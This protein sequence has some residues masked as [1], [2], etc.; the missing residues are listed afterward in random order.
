MNAKKSCGSCGNPLHSND[1]GGI[2]PRCLI[3][4]ALQGDA[5]NPTMD[6]AG[7]NYP[8]AE[9]LVGRF[10]NLEIMHL[11]GHGGMGAVYLARQT[12]LDRM[13]AL[14]V[15]SPKLG[16]DPQFTERFT[17][18]AKTLAKLSH[19]N[20]V[21]VFDYGLS[22]NIN[23]LVMEYV[24]GIN[25]RDAIEGGR[26]TAEES[27]GI[28]PQICDALQYAHNQGVIHRDI[29]PEN[30][31]LD[32]QGRV[33]IA[34]FGLAK[35]L[36]SD[37]NAFKLTGT[38]QV[39][40]TR[41]Y[42][43]PEQIEHSDVVDHRADIYSL[44]VVF[45]ELLTGELPIG[46]FAVPSEKAKVSHGLDEVVMRTLEKEPAR[47]F[48]QASEI[49]T[50]VESIVE[51]QPFSKPSPEPVPPVK[52]LGAFPFSVGLYQ[53]L[54]CARG[55]AHLYAD[56]IELEYEVVDEVLGEIKSAP[57]HTTV[58][59]DSLLHVRFVKGYLSDNVEF[60]TDRIDA[61]KD[62]PGS[63]Q[64]KFSLGTK[65]GD[66]EL[67]TRFVDQCDRLRH[68]P[69]SPSP[70]YKQST[71]H[72]EYRQPVPPRKT[73]VFVL[74]ERLGFGD[75][76][77]VSREDV[78]EKLKV[79][80]ITFLV[81]GIIHMLL[82]IRGFL[83]ETIWE[84]IE[85]WTSDIAGKFEIEFYLPRLD[86]IDFKNLLMFAVAWLLLAISSRLH[87]P[88]SYTFVFVG[89]IIVMMSPVH[90]AYVLTFFM[91]IWALLVLSDTRC[92]D[93]FQ[94]GDLDPTGEYRRDKGIFHSLMIAF[95]LLVTVA[96]IIAFASVMIWLSSRAVDSSGKPA[97]IDEVQKVDEDANSDSDASVNS[98][99]DS[100]Q[101][102]KSNTNGNEK[103][104]DD[105]TDDNPAVIDSE[106]KIDDTGKD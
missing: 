59:L 65:R 45:Y 86:S 84:K 13:V 26:L 52:T 87:R 92:K 98:G 91:A 62:V 7:S 33:K 88:R 47:R 70:G 19:P 28:V 82:A 6:A 35:L 54:A 66:M 100:E 56:R 53:G 95:S 32:G 22:E 12:N 37:H 1:P 89:L 3:G 57:K 36:D 96:T 30:I 83:R 10:P 76:V 77:N 11:V 49:R 2:C 40:G 17:R 23:Y 5:N 71:T 8:H 104:S 20:I 43:A 18:E 79:P 58:P 73:N 94:A 44:G 78:I 69:V 90:V 60:Q 25:L 97:P 105:E 4:H 64:G 14:K 29:K 51:N 106:S 61:A 42:M 55:I 63:L 38:Q 81:V 103:S 34:D 75:Q 80:R 102:T 101:D 50:A 27:L 15:L 74:G 72:P 93:V 39:L 48:Q 67:A 46:R 85:P 68:N 21:T 41:N 16:A 99:V 9:E 31:L 24:D